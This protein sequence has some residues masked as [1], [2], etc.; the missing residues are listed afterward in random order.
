MAM[1]PPPPRPPQMFGE[2]PPFADTVPPPISVPVSIQTEP[3]EPPPSLVATP[4]APLAL[5][6]PPAVRLPDATSLTAPPPAPPVG[7]R[8]LPR[9][10]EPRSTGFVTEP[11]VGPP[12]PL[13][14]P[15]LPP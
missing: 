13:P 8:K 12:V 14:S 7:P 9:P 2:L 5:I 6:V 11:Y 1:R 15:P 10:P 4:S 3:P